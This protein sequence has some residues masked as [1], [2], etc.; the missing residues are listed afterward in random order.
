MKIE[1][2]LYVCVYI[3]VRSGGQPR[4]VAHYGWLGMEEA[5]MS[6][7]FP[8]SRWVVEEIEA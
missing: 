1:T 7:G 8:R 2:R 4:Q 5:L 3:A 6:Q